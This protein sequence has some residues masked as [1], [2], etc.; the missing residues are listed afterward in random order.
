MFFANIHKSIGLLELCLVI[1]GSSLICHVIA[2]A[3]DSATTASLAGSVR[4]AA[5]ASIRGAT[6]T[7]RNLTT[8]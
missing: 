2:N 1:V 7:L 6:I 8:N 5:G 3:Q 4:D